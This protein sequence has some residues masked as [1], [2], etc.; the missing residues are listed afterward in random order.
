M[1]C[2]YQGVGT[3]SAVVT[4]GIYCL[5]GCAGRPDRANVRS[6]ALAAAAEAAGFR[7][8]HRCR[9]YRT[10]PVVRLQEAPELVCSAV[11]LIVDGILDE[12]NEQDLGVRLGISGRH[13]R[14]LFVQHLGLTPDCL[15]RSTRVHFARR[16][17]DDTD[18]SVA[19]ITF[20]AGFG[21]IRQFNRAC[22]DTFRATPGEL[23]ARRRTRDWVAVD[24]GIALRLAFEPPLD[25][26]AMLSWMRT[27][28]IPGV[29]HVTADRYCRSVLIDGDPG[30]LD[31]SLGGPDHLVLRAHLP[32]WKGLIH[33]AQR[34]RRIFGLDVDLQAASS[35]L[36]RD[37]LL[38]CLVRSRPGIRPPGT[39][40]PFETG[41]E[42]IVREYSSPETAPAIMG[43]IAARH[44]AWVPGLH[45]L[46]LARTFPTPEQLSSADLLVPGLDAGG[47]DAVRT[48]A[49]AVIAISGPANGGAQ[50]SL[51]EAMCGS[52]QCAD[53]LAWRL[54]KADAFPSQ[55]P[56]LLRAIART[57]GRSVTRAEAT[58][59]A[60]G[61]RPW[62]AHAAAYLWLSD[63]PA[64]QDRSRLGLS[65]IPLRP[66]SREVTNSLAG[67]G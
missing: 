6:F 51:V 48:L 56:A 42:A 43:E 4:T 65:S 44:G 20:A 25:W 19:D 23:R 5:P 67:R 36:A 13:L 31:V 2:Q 63:C 1:S 33:I 21:S 29:E 45:P 41:V 50:A 17:L 8:C 15:A 55:E 22:L 40:D 30:V 64:D 38:G 27:R 58:H 66:A 11:R 16:L 24:G 3:F 59:L 34:A 52:G 18:L 28:A 32:H 60:A 14:R 39:W 62:R 9:P 61:W 46:G 49:R 54:G 7:A 47:K 26:G 35:Q 10:H 53:Y 12:M 57:A 37:R